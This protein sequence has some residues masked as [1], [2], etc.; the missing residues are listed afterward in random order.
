MLEKC[1]TEIDDNEV[2]KEVADEVLLLL[3]D[4]ETYTCTSTLQPPGMCTP[5]QPPDSVHQ[6][7]SPAGALESHGE[8]SSSQNLPR[9]TS[10]KGMFYIF[11]VLVCMVI[12]YM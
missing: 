3:M 6:E 9:S 1:G 7:E 10:L 12:N 4:E 2:L 11:E 8:P 5:P